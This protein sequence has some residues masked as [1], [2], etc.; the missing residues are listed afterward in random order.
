MSDWYDDMER[1]E[2]ERD[3]LEYE[4]AMSYKEGYNQAL[5]DFAKLCLKHKSKDDYPI[6]C[7]DEFTIKRFV[8]QLKK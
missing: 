6:M 5:D 2:Q 4:C 7:F 1:T 3:A 8:E